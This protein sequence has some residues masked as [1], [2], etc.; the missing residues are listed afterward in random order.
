ML[1]I[2]LFIHPKGCGQKTKHTK[3]ESKS[4]QNRN[5]TNQANKPKLKPKPKPTKQTNKKQRQEA[6]AGAINQTYSD[7]ET[8][9]GFEFQLLLQCSPGLVA[10][11]NREDSQ[12]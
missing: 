1:N 5:K 9:E 12:P 6:K 2:R 8:R 11:L 10:L 7:R 4:N 3:K